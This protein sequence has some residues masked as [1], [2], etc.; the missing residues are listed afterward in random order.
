V[1]ESAWFDLDFAA[2]DAEPVAANALDAKGVIAR[3]GPK[4]ELLGDPGV[5]KSF[6]FSNWLD[7]YA[8]KSFIFLNIGAI[9]GSFFA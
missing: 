4:P 7:F 6:V 9:W 8:D 1:A 3:I 5:R 2:G